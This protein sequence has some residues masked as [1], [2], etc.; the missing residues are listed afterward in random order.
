[1]TRRVIEEL[2]RARERNDIIQM[3]CEQAG[4]QW[5]EAEAFVTKVENEQAHAIAGKQ[6]PLMIA[7]SAAIVA[8]GMGL[9]YYCIQ[10]ILQALHGTLLVQLL[11]LAGSAY[12]MGAGLLGLG[13]IAGGTVGLYRHWLR[14]FET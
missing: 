4:L 3:V 7:L 9:V 13:M 8:G 6:I 11:N 1:L 10:A 12:P 2:A 14:Y 5:P